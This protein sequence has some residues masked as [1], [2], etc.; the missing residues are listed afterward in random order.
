MIGK[1]WFSLL[2]KIFILLFKLKSLVLKMR[3][4]ETSNTIKV[5]KKSVN[6]TGSTLISKA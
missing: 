2:H 5:T 4:Q 6:T 3:K 1:N